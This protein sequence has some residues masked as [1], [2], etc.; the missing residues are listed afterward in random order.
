[1]RRLQQLGA[2]TNCRKGSPLSIKVLY[3][4]NETR[5]S[6]KLIWR[7]PSGNDQR[8]I[9]SRRYFINAFVRLDYLLPFTPLSSSPDS[10]PIT[11]TG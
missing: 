11:S 10:A 2:V 9:I 4:L 1:M 3:E 5:I 7:E 8:R 6:S